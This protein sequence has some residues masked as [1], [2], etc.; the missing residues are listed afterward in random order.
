MGNLAERIWY[1]TSHQVHREPLAWHRLVLIVGAAVGLLAVRLHLPFTGSESMA[2]YENIC[3]ALVDQQNWA[4][5]AL[6]G[7]LDYPPLPALLLLLLRG[8]LPGGCDPQAWLVAICQVWVFFYLCRLVHF[9]GRGKL[10]FIFVPVLFAVPALRNYLWEQNPF[11]I[12]LLVMTSTLYHISRWQREPVL[13]ELIVVAINCAILVLGGGVGIA[14]AIA[15]LML[16]QLYGRK[17]V[18]RHQG[19]TTLLFV[20]LIYLALLYP[21]CNWL[22]MHDPW[23][24]I[25]RLLAFFENASLCTVFAEEPRLAVAGIA[26]A[27]LL[28]VTHFVKSMPLDL[29][30]G[31]WL[32]AALV[33]VLAGGRA[34][35]LYFG[36]E[37]LM[38]GFCWVPMLYSWLYRPNFTECSAG[39]RFC[40]VLTSGLLMAV[41]VVLW[42]L[43]LE[44]KERDQFIGTPPTGAEI[45]AIVDADWKDSRILLFDLRS[46]AIYCNQLDNRFLARLD[47]YTDEMHAQRQD[48]QVH[49]LIP[50][51]NGRFYAPT[52]PVFVEL[53]E[54]GAHWLMLEYAWS[55][56][57][58]LWRCVRDRPERFPVGQ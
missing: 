14:F 1:G 37:F 54:H 45:A 49:L 51:N 47:Y 25:R 38:A 13:R 32:T 43:R 3:I 18:E 12:F 42:P 30:L 16:M 24:C 15:T 57:W 20:P 5:Q 41:L 21:L 46:A 8:V 58:Q 55:S 36:G 28:L 35:Q 56:G 7:V 29:R 4:K 48:E 10:F 39:A 26:V 17:R 9:T 27:V 34:S 50:P 22:I 53:H 11:W 2:V 52:D 31:F 33:I 19:L 23:F 40:M 6:V 44:G